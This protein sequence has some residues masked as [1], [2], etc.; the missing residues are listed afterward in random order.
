[1]M[2]LH[3]TIKLIISAI[4]KTVRDG[5]KTNLRGQFYKSNSSIT[6]L[7]IFCHVI[8]ALKTPALHFPSSFQ[9]DFMPCREEAQSFPC[10][11]QC[12]YEGTERVLPLFSHRNGFPRLVLSLALTF[13]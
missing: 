3:S 13:C 6:L 4:C 10:G 7:F 2:L 1:M 8:T 12:Q 11:A 9:T 5:T